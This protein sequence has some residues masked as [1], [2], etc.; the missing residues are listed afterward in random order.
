MIFLGPK[1]STALNDSHVP[2]RDPEKYLFKYLFY[3]VLGATRFCTA[4][5]RY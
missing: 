1:K 5:I 3:G 4:K 2:N